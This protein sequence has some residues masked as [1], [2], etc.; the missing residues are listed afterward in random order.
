MKTLLSWTISFV[1]FMVALAAI[2]VNSLYKREKEWQKQKLEVLEKK[3]ES[4]ETR[5]A[6]LDWLESELTAI[7]NYISVV[8]QLKLSGK[9]EFPELKR[10]ADELNQARYD[11]I[12]NAIYWDRELNKREEEK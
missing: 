10:T 3:I 1:S 9:T 5:Q 4:L 7:D 12:K 11:V 8:D 2:G 6:N